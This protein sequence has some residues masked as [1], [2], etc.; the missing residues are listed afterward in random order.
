MPGKPEHLHSSILAFLNKYVNNK[1]I[2]AHLLDGLSDKFDPEFRTAM[3]RLSERYGQIQSK[4]QKDALSGQWPIVFPPSCLDKFSSIEMR[5]G[6]NMPSINHLKT[7]IYFD[8]NDKV[9]VGYELDGEALDRKGYP[10]EQVSKIRVYL[11][12]CYLE[13]L[14]D[15]GV[16]LRD[17]KFKEGDN[18]IDAETFKNTYFTGSESAYRSVASNCEIDIRDSSFGTLNDLSKPE[19]QESD[20]TSSPNRG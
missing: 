10:A 8:E 13:Y 14:Q 9:Q 18:F 17:G 11:D 2:I 5:E 4:V 20:A 19:K 16:E 7:T 1:D 6:V 3:A 15:K 12:A